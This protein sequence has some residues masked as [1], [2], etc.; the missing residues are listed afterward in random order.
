MGL[1][2]DPE[3]VPTEYIPSEARNSSAVAAALAKR[4]SQLT[5]DDIVTLF[6]LRCNYAR[7]EHERRGKLNTLCTNIRYALTDGSGYTRRE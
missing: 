5:K 6:N 7:L 4:Y 3:R 1:A 2:V